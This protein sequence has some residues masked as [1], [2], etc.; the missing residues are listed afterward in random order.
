MLRSDEAREILAALEPL[1]DCGWL[2]LWQR[3]A[4]RKACGLVREFS[5]GGHATTFDE[6]FPGAPMGCEKRG[7]YVKLLAEP[8][9]CFVC[10]T[11]TQWVD[12]CYEAPL[13]SVECDLKAAKDAA[14]LSGGSAPGG[15]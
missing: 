7:G 5:E 15:G 8:K 1:V 4:V 6:R 9:P 2:A 13:C 14:K 12:L 10:G 3:E 11:P